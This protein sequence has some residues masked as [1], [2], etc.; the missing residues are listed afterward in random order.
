M[1]YQLGRILKAK[2]LQFWALYFLGVLPLIIYFNWPFARD[3]AVYVGGFQS[4]LQ[5]SNPYEGEVFR[6]G[7]FG[8]AFFYLVALLIPTHIESAVFISLNILGTVCFIRNLLGS[9]YRRLDFFVLTLAVWS[10]ASRE[11][12]NTIQISGIILGLTTVVLRSLDRYS[13]GTEVTLKLYPAILCTAILIDLKPHFVLPL[14]TI[15]FLRGKLFAFAGAVITFL[16]TFHLVSDFVAGK[17]LTV[18]WIKLIFNLANEPINESRKDFANVW[19]LIYWIIDLGSFGKIIPYLLIL[20]VVIFTSFSKSISK[21]ASIY[22]GLAL[23]LFS[24]Y[25]HYYD[26]VGIVALCIVSIA[27]KENVRTM[28]LAIPIIL[29][30][31]NWQKAQGL[32]LILVFFLAYF[33]CL[34]KSRVGAQIY[35]FLQ[36]SSISLLLFSITHLFQDFL[37]RLGANDMSL[38]ATTTL[39]FLTIIY[40]YGSKRS[41]IQSS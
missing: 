26:Y 19:S 23:P 22:I 20:A 34:T 29:I 2:Q 1:S 40:I 3:S 41:E 30:A 12:L 16:I 25:T 6:A 24:T 39:C 9:N 31:D 15:I 5:G 8:S 38:S 7:L 27:K 4:F 13:R 21:E 17:S 37:E 35:Y 14:F 32:L 28:T 36:C 11:G 33:F 10:S 18:E